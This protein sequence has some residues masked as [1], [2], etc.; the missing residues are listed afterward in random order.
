MA[1]AGVCGEGLGAQRSV[2]VEDEVLKSF[3]KTWVCFGFKMWFY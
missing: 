1:S 2:K 3:C